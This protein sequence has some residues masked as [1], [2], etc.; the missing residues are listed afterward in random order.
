MIHPNMLF[1]ISSQLLE[2]VIKMKIFY[3]LFATTILLTTNTF[4]NTL[5]VY[6]TDIEANKR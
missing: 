3:T 6:I 4:A 2:R 5:T 1:I